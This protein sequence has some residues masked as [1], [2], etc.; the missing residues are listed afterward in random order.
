MIAE[1][2]VR[3]P[4][5]DSETDATPPQEP[6]EPTTPLSRR[7]MLMIGA[8]GAAALASN[9]LAQEKDPL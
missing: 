7:E 2:G 1:G 6:T 9:A 5:N 3:M 4:T 8:S